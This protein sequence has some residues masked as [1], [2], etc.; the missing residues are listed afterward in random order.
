MA[1]KLAPG[2]FRCNGKGHFAIDCSTKYA[3]FPARTVKKSVQVEVFC[4]GVILTT[5]TLRSACPVKLVVV[6][7]CWAGN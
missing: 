5:I 4:L 7:V 6:I 1:S 2:C 3:Q